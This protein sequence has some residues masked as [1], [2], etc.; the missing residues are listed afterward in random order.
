MEKHGRDHGLALDVAL[1]VPD[2][3]GLESQR[4]IGSEIR[5]RSLPTEQ[6][7][8]EPRLAQ[9]HPATFLGILAIWAAAS[10]TELVL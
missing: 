9:A 1:A 2:L 10:K 3:S 7:R 6:S 4:Q 5:Y 8:D